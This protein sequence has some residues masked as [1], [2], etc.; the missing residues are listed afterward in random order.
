MSTERA[1]QAPPSLKEHTTERRLSPEPISR[2]MRQTG[3]L[4]VHALELTVRFFLGIKEFSRRSDC[5][6]P[7][8]VTRCESSVTLAEGVVIPKGATIFD[9]YLWHEH[10]VHCCSPHGLFG[11]SL[12]LRR[13]LLLSMMLLA[14]YA[15]DNEDVVEY[16][17][18]RACL[19]ISLD[20]AQEVFRRLGFFVKNPKR[21]LLDRLCDHFRRAFAESLIWAFSPLG[22]RVMKRTPALTEIWMPKATLIRL[23]GS[24]PTLLTPKWEE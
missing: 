6:L 8:A 9:L 18:I 2:F 5:V 3:I 15:A 17:A 19:S 10:L 22:T 21:S 13:R 23:Y 14:D 12:C 4:A 20:G 1:R 16:Q 24:R 11:W 7:V